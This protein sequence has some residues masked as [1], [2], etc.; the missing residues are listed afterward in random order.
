M[1]VELLGPLRREFRFLSDVVAKYYSTV[2]GAID[3][4]VHAVRPVLGGKGKGKGLT[5][6]LGV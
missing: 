5:T 4:A 2:D 6:L 1:S 3:G